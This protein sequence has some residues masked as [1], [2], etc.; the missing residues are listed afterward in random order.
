MTHRLGLW[1]RTILLAWM[2]LMGSIGGCQTKLS[3][4][5]PG[6][7]TSQCDPTIRKDCWSVSAQFVTERFYYEEQTIRL[8]DALKTCRE[9]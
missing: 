8:K 1:P 2:L 9:K 7:D 5:L 4:P 3:N 6:L